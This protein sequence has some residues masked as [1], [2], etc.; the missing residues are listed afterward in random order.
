MYVLDINCN[1]LLGLEACT[2]LN[3]IARVNEIS[4][5]DIDESIF[6]GIGCLPSI[7]KILLDYNVTTVVC[8]SRKIPI[9]LRPRLQD[10]LIK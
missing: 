4:Q 6:N 5:Y 8:G 3:L 10:E 9:K 2:K 7:C 1:N